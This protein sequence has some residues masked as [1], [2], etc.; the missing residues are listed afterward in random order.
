MYSQAYQ[1]TVIG[2]SVA[3][4]NDKLVDAL[5]ARRKE[6]VTRLAFCLFIS[7]LLA[8]ASRIPDLFVS[9]PA[10]WISGGLSIAFVWV[11]GP[12]V[13]IVLQAYALH[14]LSEAEQLRRLLR[15]QSSGDSDPAGSGQLGQELAPI[16][17][18]RFPP[19]VHLA[20]AVVLI[21]PTLA[22]AVLFGS[23]LNLV[24]PENGKPLYQSR[25]RQMI[26]AFVGTGG[27]NG[28]LPIAPSLQDNLRDLEEHAK[29]D[30]NLKYHI[31][32]TEIPWT[33][34]P[35]QTW[36]YLLLF[37]ISLDG[38]LAGGAYMTGTSALVESPLTRMWHALSRKI[39]GF[40]K[41]ANKKFARKKKSQE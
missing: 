23:Y 14:G 21:A 5:F 25:S 36:L 16:W 38:A 19:V 29:P 30:D 8:V 13:L 39:G 7:A 35:F 37:L 2:K 3:N 32:A 33:Y 41:S 10:A 15:S 12:P 31:L 1:S 34:F 6:A 27:W 4:M 40:L 9:L 22:N 20:L 26:D 18:K 28:F 11:I 17:R 24:R